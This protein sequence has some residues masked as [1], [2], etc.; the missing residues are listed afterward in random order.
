MI[1]IIIGPPC[2]GKTTYVSAHATMG[3]VVLDWDKLAEALDAGGSGVHTERDGAVK[4]ATTYARF[5]VAN[6]LTTDWKARRDDGSEATA[7]VIKTW[8][9]GSPAVEELV[10]AGG[11][12]TIIDP[13]EPECLARAERD[14]RPAAT[15]DAIRAW[16][17]DPPIIPN[18]W[19]DTVVK[20]APTMRAKNTECKVK[21]TAGEKF[22]NPFGGE[23]RE[24]DFIAYASTFDADPDSYGD[25]MLPGSFART[26]KEWAEKDAPIPLLYG[27][28]MDDPAYNIG[29][30]VDAKEDEHGLLVWG[31]IDLETEAGQ[32]AYKLLKSRRLAQLSF[33]FD[34]ID[35]EQNKHGGYDIA[36]VNLHEVSLVQLGANRHTSVLAVKAAADVVQTTV[37]DFTEDERDTIQDAADALREALAQLDKLLDLDTEGEENTNE[38]LEDDVREPVEATATEQVA[39]RN[40]AA[41]RLALALANVNL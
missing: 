40:A 18:T 17:Q 36:D 22:E 27:H 3:D 35:G 14:D 6:Y 13:G 34:L 41:A 30:I 24:G 19:T 33:A 4:A 32:Q 2:A 16:Y 5:T 28:R 26:L 9:T 11:R 25:V 23:M 39:V 21:A 7:W 37:G 8:A 15:L 12:V 31:R 1:R 29:Y 20:G 38:N 10:A